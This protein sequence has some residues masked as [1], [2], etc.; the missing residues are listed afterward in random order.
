LD[1][2]T[3]AFAVPDS[4]SVLWHVPTEAQLRYHLSAS[5]RVVLAA[6]SPSGSLASATAFHATMRTAHGVESFPLLENVGWRTV[7]AATIEALF[8]EVAAR[9]ATG[10]KQPLVTATNLPPVDSEL[11]RQAGIRQLPSRFEA[12]VAAADPSHL[13][14]E[15]RRTNLE[16]V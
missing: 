7:D 12:F 4:P 10:G 2:V 6:S 11:L 13:L 16:V 15:A 8:R 5:S 9:W 14:L 1:A 3:S